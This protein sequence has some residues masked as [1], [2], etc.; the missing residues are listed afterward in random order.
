MTLLTAVDSKCLDMIPPLPQSE[1]VP[2][3]GQG[4]GGE[5]RE[6]VLALAI[7]TETVGGAVR[8]LLT[9]GVQGEKTGQ[10]FCCHEYK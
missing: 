6:N 8:D 5:G 10:S 2:G 7:A 9:G 3:Q 1:D 4:S